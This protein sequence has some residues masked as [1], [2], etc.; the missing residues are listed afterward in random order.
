MINGGL[1]GES[2]I[3][4]AIAG[5]WG[6]PPIFVAGDEVTCREVQTLVGATVVAAPVKRGLGRFAARHLA[7]ADARA[8]IEQ[9]AEAALRNRAGWPKPL[10]FAPP[11]TFQVELATPDHTAFYHGRTNVEIIGPRAVRATGKTF[12]EAWDA[13]WYR[14]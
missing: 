5:C 6:T 3:I 4:A 7:P 8:L 14:S 2:G 13:F 11:V 10:T 12:W 9:K 1:V